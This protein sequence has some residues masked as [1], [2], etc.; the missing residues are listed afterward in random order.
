LAGNRRMRK[1]NEHRGWVNER[2][3]LKEG[4]SG[5]KEKVRMWEDENVRKREEEKMRKFGD[6]EMRK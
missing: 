2:S 6:M 1:I 3:S 4:R 5:E